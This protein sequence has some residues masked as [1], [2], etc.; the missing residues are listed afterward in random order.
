MIFGNRN[1]CRWISWILFACFLHTRTTSESRPQGLVSTPGIP[2]AC[3][4][5]NFPTSTVC[6][7]SWL[8]I[9]LASPYDFPNKGGQQV[10]PITGW[11]AQAIHTFFSLLHPY[12]VLTNDLVLQEHYATA[13]RH[14][15]KP[16]SPATASPSPN[17]SKPRSPRPPAPPGAGYFRRVRVLKRE[18]ANSSSFPLWGL[19]CKGPL[20][21]WNVM[22]PTPRWGAGCTVDIQKNPMSWKESFQKRL[23]RTWRIAL[24]F[25]S[26]IFLVLWS[27]N[28]NLWFSP[29]HEKLS[30][31]KGFGK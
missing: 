6:L 25:F 14:Y 10:N 28:Q 30:F 22:N 13:T 18:V 4:N 3:S 16:N 24:S 20:G 23:L 17:D 19:S 11:I 8:N 12:W 2:G 15:Q 31:P 27:L 5:S 26:R 1:S 9:H 7:G 29:R 21:W